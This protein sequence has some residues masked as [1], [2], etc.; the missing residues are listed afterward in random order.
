MFLYSS[1]VVKVMLTCVVLVT[2]VISV[3]VSHTA[4]FNLVALLPNSLVYFP[5][6][7]GNAIQ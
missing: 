6:Y 7:S 4:C 1:G 3:A 5:V 2:A